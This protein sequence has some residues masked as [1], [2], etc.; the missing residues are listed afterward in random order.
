MALI[1]AGTVAASKL[2]DQLEF[3][4][5]PHR[6]P[7]HHPACVLLCAVLALVCVDRWPLYGLLGVGVALGYTLHLAA[8]GLTLHGIPRPVG[9]KRLHFL[10]PGMRFETGD[11]PEKFFAFAIGLGMVALMYVQA[12]L[13]E[14][15]Y[16]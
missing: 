16:S 7:T 1:V 6:G 8:D 13:I 4:P 15:T 14:R 10:P 5:I 2:P 3:G 9:K 11:P 12:G